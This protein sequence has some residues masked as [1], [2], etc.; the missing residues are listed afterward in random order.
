MLHSKTLHFV[1]KAG[2]LLSTAVLIACTQSSGNVRFT[3]TGDESKL[4]VTT[5]TEEARQES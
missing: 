2:V 5:R 4:P 3:G 1:S